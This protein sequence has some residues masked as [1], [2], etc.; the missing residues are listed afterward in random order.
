[1]DDSEDHE[2]LREGV[3]AVVSRFDDYYWF[4]R[5]DDGLFPFAFHKAMAEAGLLEGVLHEDQKR[6]DA[7]PVAFEQRAEADEVTPD[8]AEILVG[9][10]RPFGRADEF[11]GRRILVHQERLADVKIAEFDI[12]HDRIF[13][14]PA[15]NRGV[16]DEMR[17]LE[18]GD[19][20]FAGDQGTDKH[21]VR[22][23]QAIGGRG[24]EPIFCLRRRHDCNT[25]PVM[26]ELQAQTGRAASALAQ[27]PEVVA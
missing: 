12:L 11:H 13:A 14:T 15:E 23:G 17:H 7:P 10:E 19:V 3:R 1:M 22:F 6:R 26:N 4:A 20:A 24:S 25:S 8:G 27:I 2:A 5:D 16:F 21:C 9:D 18:T